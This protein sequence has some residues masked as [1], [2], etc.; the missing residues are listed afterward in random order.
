MSIQNPLKKA[1]NIFKLLARHLVL[2]LS[3]CS[4]ERKVMNIYDILSL[5]IL[6]IRYDIPEPRVVMFGKIIFNW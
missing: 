3:N 5:F 6:S 4:I 1:L 2:N